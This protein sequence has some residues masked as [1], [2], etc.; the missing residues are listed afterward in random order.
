MYRVGFLLLGFLAFS[1]HAMSGGSNSATGAWPS[2]V[3]VVIPN[4]V[5]CGGLLLRQNYVVT[6]AACLLNN[7]FLLL[8]AN[9]VS[10]LAGV[11]VINFALPRVQ[12]RALYVHPQFN[13]LTSEND[14]GVIRVRSGITMK[15]TGVLIIS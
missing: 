1:A 7:N 11:T 10:V 3:A 4:N 12:S 13:P 5:V 2:L 9:Q 14:I 8:N 15:S 6:S